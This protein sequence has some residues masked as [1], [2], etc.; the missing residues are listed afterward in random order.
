MRLLLIED[1]QRLLESLTEGLSRAG[2]AVD[3]AA[4]IE[5]A[6]AILARQSF[7]II[8]LDRWLPDG[9][10]LEILDRLRAAGDETHVLVLTARDTINDRVT[11]L[12]RGADDYLIKPFAFDEL[13]ARLDTIY[14]RSQRRPGPTLRIGALSVD[15]ATRSVSHGDVRIELTA[16]EYALFEFL[17]FRAGEVVTRRDL[18]HHLYNAQSAPTSNAIDRLICAIRAKLNDAD[19]PDPIRT[20]RGIGYALASDPPRASTGADA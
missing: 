9:D 8:I 15:T 19:V 10:G 4:S 5:R 18:E 7:E 2:H 16:R 13:L 1:S 11:G 14:R 17:A 12:R 6:E 20:R 3:T